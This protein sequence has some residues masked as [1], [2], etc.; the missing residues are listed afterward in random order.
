MAKNNKKELPEIRIKNIAR[1]VH[2][3]FKYLMKNLSTNAS[4]FL[5]PIIRQK[6]D[7]YPKHLR[8]KPKDE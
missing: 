4:D 7:E 2:Q 5:R 3:E 6:L 8:E 1:P